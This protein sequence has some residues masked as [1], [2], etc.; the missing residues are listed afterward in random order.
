MDSWSP[1]QGIP[2]QN[3]V[4]PG[5]AI[6][7][8][9]IGFQSSLA[10]ACE[11]RIAQTLATDL[12]SLQCVPGALGDHFPLVLCHGSKDVHRQ[13]VGVRVIDRH[14]LDAAV[15]QR[16]NKCQIAAQWIELSDYE[17]GLALLAGC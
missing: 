17:L 15:H 7:G 4:P 14:E 2:P 3:L 6:S 16:G 10:R 13:L 1:N 5:E 12:G 8:R 9:A 11:V